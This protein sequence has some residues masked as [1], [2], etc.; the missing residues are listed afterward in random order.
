V[1]TA[2]PFEA[3]E[4]PPDRGRLLP[5]AVGHLSHDLR[6]SLHVIRGHAEL[7]G[8]EAGDDDISESTHAIVDACERLGDLCDDI[9]DFLRL[10]AVAPGALV[11]LALDDLGRSL[12]LLGPGGSPI[13]LVEPA[14][15]ARTAMVRSAVRR[16]VSHVLAHVVRATG[17][18]VTIVATTHPVRGVIVVS[19][20]PDGFITADDGIIAVAAALLAAHGGSLGL[21]DDRI[22]LMFPLQGRSR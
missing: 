22:E 10:P 17:S 19:S 12:G 3:P 8:A 11:D 9:V 13:R 4:R 15:G 6:G 7:L 2:E 5:A 1:I 18:R 21:L 14:T 20:V 16:V